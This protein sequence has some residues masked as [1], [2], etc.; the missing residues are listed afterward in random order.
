[1]KRFFKIL[2]LVL[3]VFVCFS[4]VGCKKQENVKVFKD[5][6]LTE[7]DYAFAVSKSNAQLTANVNEWIAEAKENGELNALIDSYF[8]NTATFTYQNKTSLPQENDFVMATNANFPPFEF[9]E[10]AAFKGIDVEIAHILATR[11]NKNLFVLDMNFDSIIPSVNTGESDIGMAGMTVNEDRLKTVDFTHTYYTSAQVLTVREGDSTFD[12]CSTAEEVVAV[13]KKQNKAYTIG[14]QEG[15]TGYY[16]TAGNEDFDYDGFPNLTAKSYTAG[17]LAMTDLKNRRINAVILDL[18]P[19]LSIAQGLE[20]AS[21]TEIFYR[22]FITLGGYRSFLT[23]LANTAMIAV[24]G[25]LIGFFLGSII[26]TVKIVPSKNPVL[27]ATKKLCDCYVA[28]FRGTPMV[29]QLLLMHF[30]LFPMLGIYINSV[31]E[32][33]LIFGMNSAAYMSEILRSGI[34]AV[35]RGQMEAGRSLGFGF[36]TTMF[37]IILPQAIKNILPTLGNEFIALIKETSVVS[38]IAVV[39]L[40]KAFQNIGNATY[41]YFVPYIVLA[42]VYLVLVF[43]ITQLIKFIEKRLAKNE[44]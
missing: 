35:D 1:M 33:M 40:T 2:L 16:Y 27:T 28:V 8:D 42:A 10:G 18:Q 15:T 31:L 39:D 22:Q 37:R 43:A 6:R 3:T 34:G 12:G 26:A 9:V 17:A 41:E 11:L 38:F 13:L 19:S 23:G 32:A 4:F 44:R 5:I 7:E 20:S 25:L 29:V 21:K 30:A 36:W 24:F 14:T